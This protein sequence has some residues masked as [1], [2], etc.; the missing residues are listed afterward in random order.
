MSPAPVRFE[1]VAYNYGFIPVEPHTN[2][3]Y[4]LV[5][6]LF[7]ECME[8]PGK[9][10]LIRGNEWVIQMKDI[11]GPLDEREKITIFCQDIIDYYPFNFKSKA[12]GFLIQARRRSKTGYW[13]VVFQREG[14]LEAFCSFLY[15]LIHG[16]LR[17][18]GQSLSPNRDLRSASRYHNSPPRQRSRPR[19]HVYADQ[20]SLKYGG[21]ESVVVS[22]NSSGLTL[23]KPESLRTSYSPSYTYYESSAPRR[24]TRSTE[25][26]S[27]Y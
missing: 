16:R 12:V 7:K 10:V 9:V 11:S 2:R 21:R 6:R 22:C 18:H 23:Y 26:P 8:E 5:Y 19:S 17:R 15:W 20:H 24:L 14:Q 3:G 27:R 13:F 25:R 4:C 1:E